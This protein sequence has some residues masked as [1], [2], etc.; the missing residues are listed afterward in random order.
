MKAASQNGAYPVS[1]PRDYNMPRSSRVSDWRRVQIILPY[2][3]NGFANRTLVRQISPFPEQ[4]E[5]LI[6]SDLVTLNVMH[7]I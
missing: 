2:F 5:R 3:H 4:L 6:R 7:G 1:M